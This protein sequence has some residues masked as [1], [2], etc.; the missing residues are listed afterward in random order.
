MLR[1]ALLLAGLILATPAFADDWEPD[2]YDAVV[3]AKM[4]RQTPTNFGDCGD[5]PGCIVLAW[6]W[7]DRLEIERVEEGLPLP[8]HVEVLV[9]QHSYFDSDHFRRWYLRRNSQGGFNLLRLGEPVSLL[10]C[11]PGTPPAKP[12]LGLKE[13]QTLRDII[14][15]TERDNRKALRELER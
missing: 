4:V 12:Y 15:R 14:R 6:P 3:T 9:V 7:I 13:G 1:A 10:R 2:C 11:A 8:R 5:E